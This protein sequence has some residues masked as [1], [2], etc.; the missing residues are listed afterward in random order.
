LPIAL[1]VIMLGM[2]LSLT[3][4]DF[5]RVMRAPKAFAVGIACQLLL[6]PAV[7][8][9][10]AYALDLPGVLATGLVI[11]ALCPGGTTSNMFAYLA[12]GDVALSISLT[13]VV[14]LIAPFT[15]PIF[16]GIAMRQ[17]M[18]ESQVIELP[19]AK[20]ILTLLLITVVPVAI[21]MIIR[22]KL[23]KLADRSEKPVKIL[24]IV[25]LAAIIAGIMKSNGSNLMD[26]FAAAGWAALALNISTMA[27]GFAAA[28]AFRLSRP[29]SI[30]IGLEVGIQNGTTALFVTNTLLLNPQMSIAP[31]VYSII[32]FV[33][34]AFIGLAL[35]HPRFRSSETTTKS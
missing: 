12:G 2:G 35:N 34:G 18:G 17:F 29:Q 4:A 13:A 14:S 22:A 7:G 32:M 6:L 30:T 5:R 20:T 16:A 19:L 23:P 9:G 27:L 33:T 15:I 28:A 11:L 1:A 8:F 26:F 31:A 3:L 24:S 25:F 21:G 10:L